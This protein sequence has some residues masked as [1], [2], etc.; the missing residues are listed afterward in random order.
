MMLLLNPNKKNI[1]SQ[2]TAKLKKSTVDSSSKKKSYQ[3]TFQAWPH[4]CKANY[5]HL[6]DSKVICHVPS[7]VLCGIHSCM[8][9]NLLVSPNKKCSCPNPTN[10]VEAISRYATNLYMS[11]YEQ[12][13]FVI[14]GGSIHYRITEVH[15]RM[16]RK[17][18]KAYLRWLY[19]ACTI[20][21]W[22]D[23]FIQTSF[24]PLHHFC[25]LAPLLN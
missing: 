9:S 10:Y 16:L 2:N 25:S 18:Y 19:Y 5:F 13:I 21:T 22:C 11:I 1:L 6:N 3:K 4:A 14:Q 23:I 20:T 12:N 17:S 8:N 24:L 7:P 15:P